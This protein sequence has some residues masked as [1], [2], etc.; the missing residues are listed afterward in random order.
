MHVSHEPLSHQYDQQAFCSFYVGCSVGP[1]DDENSQT[2]SF[3]L[4]C[5]P[6]SYLPA[7]SRR[8]S[9]TG[10]ILCCG[11]L[12]WPGQQSFHSS[13]C[14]SCASPC[15]RGIEFKGYIFHKLFLP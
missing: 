4:T 9:G 5:E 13:K 7:L 1:D 14:N 12:S 3:S 8:G 2:S 15:A 10:A 6:S 11:H